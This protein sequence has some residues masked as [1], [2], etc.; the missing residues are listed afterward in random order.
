MTDLGRPLAGGTEEPL[1]AQLRQRIVAA[2]GEGRLARGHPLPPSRRLAKQLGV[3]RNTVAA[4]YDELRERG[5]LASAPRQGIF[6]AAD[7]PSLPPLRA[8]AA[9]VLRLRLRPSE[10]RNIA[11]PADWQ[12]FPF[13]FVYGQVDPEL[14]PLA[15]WRACSREALGRSAVNWWAADHATAD[16]PLLIEQ[17]RRHILPARG[18]HARPE[19]VLV[20]L[21]SQH[22]LFLLLQLLGGPGV[23]VG[24]EDPGYPDARNMAALGG[25]A[26]RLLP[27]DGEGLMVGPALEGVGLAVVTPGH[28]CPSMVTLPP[29]RRAALLRWA[30]DSGA[31]L[32]E[33]DYESETAQP[34]APP[35]LA[36]D[37]TE[38][39]VL[40]LGTFSKVLAPGMRLGFLVGP[41][42]VIA[43]ARA[44][45][46]LMH[47]S[48]PLNNQRTAALFI[49][50]GHY[51]RLR[52]SLAATAEKRRIAVLAALRRELPHFT[53]SP[54]A[55]G[56]SL[57]LRGPAGLDGVV[58]AE[59]ARARGVIIEPGE[60]FFADPAAGR[61]FLRL[62]LSSIPTERIAPGI[63]ALAAA[64][65]DVPGPREPP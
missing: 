1:Q 32:I 22:G 13:P 10:Q 8:P 16:D 19:E 49:A 63:A 3:A 44:L 43:E 26:T 56:S 14:F 30:R 60:P 53:P 42:A 5:L 31:V 55:A 9:A 17:I 52:R 12:S 24:L 48:V 58:L 57:W 61:N 54:A 36:A 6:V 38:G 47:R 59:A 51:G 4:V 40:H 64:V 25:S 15:D 18:L 34:G 7:A 65:R 35:C 46:R 11:K 29:A 2:I 20:T 33:D 50:E 62:G 39:R 41:A 37:D 28:H 27:V 23:T 21:G 45:R